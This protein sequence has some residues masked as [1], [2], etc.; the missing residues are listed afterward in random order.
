M[1]NYLLLG[2]DRPTWHISVT[3][4]LSTLD[5]RWRAA[6]EDSAALTI[7]VVTGDR[8]EVHDLWV[9][10]RAVSWYQVVEVP[11]PDAMHV[12][13]PRRGPTV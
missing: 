6:Y 10:P 3:E 7:Q 4:D 8:L 1:A 12:S 5:A 13:I 11:D 2:T 9:N